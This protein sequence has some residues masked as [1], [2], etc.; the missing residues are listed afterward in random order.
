YEEARKKL[1]RA[2]DTSD[3]E[4]EIDLGRGRRKKR[5]RRALSSSPEAVMRPPLPPHFM[6]KK[7][8]GRRRRSPPH[9]LASSEPSTS[10]AYDET[11][12]VTVFFAF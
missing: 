11:V 2:E 7:A 1:R 8:A 10:V 4:S 12:F 5:Q 6:M 3:L 9:S